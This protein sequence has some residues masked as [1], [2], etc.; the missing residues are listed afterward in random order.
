MQSFLLFH[1][2]TKIQQ[3]TMCPVL[4]FLQAPAE[5]AGDRIKRM[6]REHNTRKQDEYVNNHF[7]LFTLVD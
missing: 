7:S 3:P 4:M 1:L 5:S 6:H 2:L